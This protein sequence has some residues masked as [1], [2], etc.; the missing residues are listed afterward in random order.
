MPLYASR[1]VMNSKRWLCEVDDLRRILGVAAVSLLVA[2]ALSCAQFAGSERSARGGTTPATQTS[3]QSV[4][5]FG[6]GT[7]GNGA[8]PGASGAPAASTP[9]NSRAAPSQGSLFDAPRPARVSSAGSNGGAAP[10]ASHAPAGRS[11]GGARPATDGTQLV[12]P[13][14]RQSQSGATA[15]RENA[16]ESNAGRRAS[17]F[18]NPPPDALRTLFGDGDGD[19]GGLRRA[20]L[21]QGETP[22]LEPFRTP[23]RGDVIMIDPGHGD[24]DP[25][26]I[27]HGMEEKEIA[28]D[29]SLRLVRYLEAAGF[30]VALTRDDDSYPTLTERVEMTEES[31]AILFLS[32]HA[33]AA[34]RSSAR[35]VETFYWG[36]GQ[37]ASVSKRLAEAVQTQKL[38]VAPTLD[39]G[40]KTPTRRLM[41]LADAKWPAALTEL[42]FM[43]NAEDAAYLR[44]NQMREELARALYNG[45]VAFY[46][47]AHR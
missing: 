1:V 31:G 5:S 10:A 2:G 23:R 8:A 14:P 33:N 38:K 11:G 21:P 15:A 27:A 17:L 28:L 3:G 45:I 43:T 47:E 42:G 18:D 40:A 9:T 20:N 19:R 6:S 12:T 46:N 32:V 34:D 25:G 37:Y 30:P 13:P 16:G 29:V 22:L 24:H 41:V 35:G 7:G 44:D 4:F 36:R 39:R 26:A